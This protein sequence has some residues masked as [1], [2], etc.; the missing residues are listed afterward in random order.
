[1]FSRALN[2]TGAFPYPAGAAATAEN[3]YRTAAPE[4]FGFAKFN[5]LCKHRQMPSA[6]AGGCLVK[7]FSCIFYLRCYY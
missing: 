5:C 3:A 4:Q 1:M 7:S 2:T 6:A